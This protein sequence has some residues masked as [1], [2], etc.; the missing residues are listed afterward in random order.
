MLNCQPGEQISVSD[1]VSEINN[2]LDINGDGS[3][4]TGLTKSQVGLENV[5]NTS[6]ADKPISDAT[7]IALDAKEPSLGLGSPGQVLATNQNANGK[8][9]VDMSGGGSSAWA[10]IDGI[11]EPPVIKGSSNI[12]NVV[13]TATGFLTLEFDTPMNDVNYSVVATIEVEGKPNNYIFVFDKTINSFQIE[14]H[15]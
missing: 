9:W 2:K 5:D 1:I 10:Y 8:E 3:N 11:A 14:T 4:L 15:E 7:Q 6:D 12:S 13:R